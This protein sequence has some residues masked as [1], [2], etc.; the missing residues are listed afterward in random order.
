MINLSHNFIENIPDLQELA[1][2]TVL[3]LSFN[4]VFRDFIE[5][6]KENV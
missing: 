6:S 1:S 4:K 2:L 3:N 5:K